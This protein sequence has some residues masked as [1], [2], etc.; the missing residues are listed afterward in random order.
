MRK[1][2]EKNHTSINHNFNNFDSA[3]YLTVV[4]F[5]KF[6]TSVFATTKNYEFDPQRPFLIFV[7]SLKIHLHISILLEKKRFEFEH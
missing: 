7:A 1:S 4:K 3:I 2:F 6:L 5:D